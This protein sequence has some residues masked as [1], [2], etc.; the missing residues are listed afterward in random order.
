MDVH[1]GGSTGGEVSRL[2]V[3]EGPTGRGPSLT[4]FYDFSEELLQP[5]EAVS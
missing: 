3:I 1:L 4:A 2:E 5:I